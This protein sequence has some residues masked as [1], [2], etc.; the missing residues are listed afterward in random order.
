M[1]ADALLDYCLAKPG[2]YLDFPFGPEVAV[3]KV[4]AP[5]QPAGKV[6][7]EVFTLR[8]EPNT[9]LSCDPVTAEL[10]RGLYPGVIVRG[11][12]CPPVQQP[13]VNCLPLAGQVPEEDI[14]ELAD[15][16]YEVVVAKLPKYRQRELAQAYDPGLAG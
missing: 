6:F 13:Y 7:A 16:A 11:Y 3:V 2:A 5:S 14:L 10:F 4:K 15:L 1:E 9:N 12:H 8:G